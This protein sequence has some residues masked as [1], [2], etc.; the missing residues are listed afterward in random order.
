MPQLYHLTLK[1]HNLHSYYS[2]N[3]L[4]VKK[5]RRKVI[6]MHSF[7]KLYFFFQIF[8]S[9][10]N[11]SHTTFA[12]KEKISWPTSLLFDHLLDEAGSGD[13]GDDDSTK[14]REGTGEVDDEG[15]NG[16]EKIAKIHQTES[17]KKT[18]LG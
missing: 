7:Q 14:K 12:H 15:D 9:E 2:V 18:N 8:S 3:I 13:S 17:E 10:I 16:S 5:K 1:G 4:Q 6:H 11:S